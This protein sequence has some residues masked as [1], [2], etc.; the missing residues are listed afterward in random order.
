MEQIKISG[1]YDCPCSPITALD[2]CLRNKEAF[3]ALVIL[4][5]NPKIVALN[6]CLDITHADIIYLSERYAI[7]DYLYDKVE[8]CN[9]TC[10]E[11]VQAD[12]EFLN[13]DPFIPVPPSS[14]K[15]NDMD[16]TTGNC[17]VFGAGNSSGQ[18]K[19]TVYVD[20]P[21]AGSRKSWRTPTNVG[22]AFIG[23][24]QTFNGETK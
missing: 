19:L 24:E 10:G 14:T 1:D 7:V 8:A 23:M 18:H 2:T 12:F 15:I 17:F 13:A 9:C 21:E 20:Q 3:K 22:H 11:A 6:N 5:K 16:E 4:E